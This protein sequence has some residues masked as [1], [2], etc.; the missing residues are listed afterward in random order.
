MKHAT[1]TL[2]LLLSPA[3][4]GAQGAIDYDK[5]IDADRAAEVALARSAA[6]KYI[7]DSATVLYLT[8][9]GYV[10]AAKGTNG[11]V[12]LVVREYEA[13]LTDIKVWQETH[14]RAPHCLNPGA[15]RTILPE[16]TYRAELVLS[17]LPFEKVAAQL[18]EGYRTGRLKPAEVGA[19][20]YMLSRHQILAG[21]PPHWKPHLMFY[22]PPSRRSEA[23][24]GGF[25][26]PVID[27]GYDPLTG[28]L[29]LIPVPHWSDG[30]PAN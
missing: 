6:P 27:A 5:Y 13:S 12:C 24:A 20:A 23:G 25:D 21:D 4:L 28:S 30:T 15:V 8:R 16:M 17:G 14:R 18:Q 10:E 1:L 19:M 3:L 29:I 22:Y 7:A 11:F 2:S 26:A 9:T